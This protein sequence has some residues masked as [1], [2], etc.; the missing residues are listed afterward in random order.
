VPSERLNL[1]K[2]KMGNRSHLNS[3]S[4]NIMLTLLRMKLSSLKICHI[5]TSLGFLD[6]IDLTILIEMEQ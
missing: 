3:L 4:K 1:P 6:I 5:Q 2:I